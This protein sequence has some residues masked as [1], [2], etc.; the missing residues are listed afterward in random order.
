VL[1]IIEKKILDA[2][3][4]GTEVTRKRAIF[5][6]AKRNEIADK[7]TQAVIGQAHPRL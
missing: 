3:I 5:F 1:E 7:F 6:T 4:R 2:L